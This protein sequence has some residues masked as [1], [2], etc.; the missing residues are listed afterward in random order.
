M[1]GYHDYDY[2]IVNDE[3]DVAVD[4]LR[5]IVMAERARVHRMRPAADAIINTFPKRDQD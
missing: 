4:A 5:S 1:S 2:V 3:L